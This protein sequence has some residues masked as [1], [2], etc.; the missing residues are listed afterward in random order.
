MTDIDMPYTDDGEISLSGSIE[1]VIY[2]N[3]ENGYS[4]CDMAT[5][6][7]AIVTIVGIMPFVC[8]GDSVSVIGKWV[9]NP[10][11]GRQFNVSKYEKR[12]PADTSS[13]LRYLSSRTV[14]GI[15][16][17][18]AQ[19]IVEKFG[20]DTFDVIENHPMWL[21]E[22]KGVSLKIA[23][24]ASEDFKRQTGIR[25]AMLFFREYFGSTMTVRIYKKWG[26]GCVD[27]AKKNPY[28][29]CNEIEGIGF[30]KADMMAKDLGISGDNIDR[31]I[32]GIRY[33]LL[34]NSHQNGHVCL[35]RAKL[36]ES[37]AYL[38]GISA[39][40]AQ[41][42]VGEALRQ[43]FLKYRLCEGEQMIYLSEL[44]DAEKYIAKKLVELDRM[45]AAV[46][47]PDI[48][49]FVEMEEQKNGISYAVQQK[50][51]ITN[52][53][54]YGVMILTGGPGTGKTTIV[55]A[56]IHIFGS[57][58]LKVALAAPTGRA[59]KRLSE[60]TSKEA[61]TVHR[62][63]E[64]S[65]SEG[66]KAQ[67]G[68]DEF[69]LLEQDVIIIDEASMLD[70]MLTEALLR[71]IKPGARLI[72]IGDADQLPSVGAGN[73][74]QDLISSD[75]FPTVRLNEIFRQ[76]QES[77]IVTNA[78][79]INTGELPR[80]DVKD[81]DFFFMYRDSD[82]KIAHTIVEL[83]QSRLP[84]KYGDMA[85][86]GIQVTCP[87]RKGE[88]GTDNLNL[89]LQAALNP[90]SD[91]KREYRF[92][93]VVFR[94]GDKVMQ[95]RNNYDLLWTRESDGKEGS[96]VFNGDIGVI[97]EIN[98]SEKAMMIVFDDRR[99][100]YDLSLLD[101]IEHAYAITVHKSQGSEYPIVIIPMG[102]APQM[103]L[104]RN[105]LYTAVTR[106]QNMVILVGAEEKVWGMVQNNKQSMR[107][108]GL[109]DVLRDNG[110]DR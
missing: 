47:L 4:I 72:I 12:L 8:A 54:R 74:L 56:L 98:F 90:A 97:D 23:N 15:G 35:P 16:P 65:Y 92:R 73:I 20:E 2:S 110:A 60:S 61:K 11:Y 43:G 40:S 71:A 86:Y 82:R 67:F 68:R 62:L 44:Y 109:C 36:C 89:L 17:K 39:E 76:A 21:T 29:L 91:S 93:E 88:S 9:H 51:A 22:I 26:S 38:L 70:L 83:C 84:R 58:D 46:S 59:A 108:T 7:E 85:R 79:R 78:H 55:R 49:R 5:S 106:A 48:D 10:K 57:M 96:G 107:Y 6:D 53:L 18:T 100:C 14:K 45:C 99:V 31:I 103:L 1:S 95:T 19:R 41:E 52:A 101:D 32:S 69:D 27:M 3:E 104:T 37:A 63:L 30:E 77:L 66:G 28:R 81:N 13:I 64:M 75:R 42:G 94:E 34:S 33:L 25:S 24:A 87:S 105:L 102:S 80:L 50:A